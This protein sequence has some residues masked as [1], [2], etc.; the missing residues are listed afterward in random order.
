[1]MIKIKRNKLLIKAKSKMRVITLNSNVSWPFKNLKAYFHM[2]KI[3]KQF[4]MSIRKLPKL[5]TLA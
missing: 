2:R 4:Q 5:L 3:T 1:M